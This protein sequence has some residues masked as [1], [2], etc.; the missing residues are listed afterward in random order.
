MGDIMNKKGWTLVGELFVF[1]IAIIFLIYSIYGLY[2]LGFVKSV[3]KAIPGAKPQLI[4]SGRIVNYESVESNLVNAT[5]RYVFDKHNN[6]FNSD[7]IVVRVNTL[8]EYG[9]ISTIRDS[10]N[11][12]C[13]GY[14]K[15]Y[16]NGSNL[17]YYPYLNCSTY[18]SIGYEKDYDF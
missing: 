9:Y 14:V 18:T 7:V 1:L 16:K 13:S 6:S 8:I 10:R 15:V 11:K 5:K 2:R 4:I 3:D 12:K 17:S